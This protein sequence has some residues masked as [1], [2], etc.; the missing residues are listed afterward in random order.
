MASKPEKKAIDWQYTEGKPAEAARRK[1]AESTEGNNLA[2]GRRVGFSNEPRYNL[3]AS[4]R[5][6]FELTDGKLA[7]RKDD[8]IWFNRDAVGWTNAD[9]G[10]T[11]L[12]DLGEKRRVGKVAIRLL[13]GREQGSL[14]F[15]NEIEVIGSADGR[16]Y[17][18]L[19]K[20]S[21]VTFSEKEL[22][23]EKPESFFYLPE[24]GNAYVETFLFPIQREVRHVGL[25]IKSPTGF[26]FS[27]QL[28]VIEATPDQAMSSLTELP[29]TTITTHGL[30]IRPRQEELMITSNV[31]T[32]NWF[33]VTDLREEKRAASFYFDLPEGI[34]LKMGPAGSAV[35]R[36]SAEHPNRWVIEDLYHGKRP[37]YSNV[38]GPFYFTV[39]SGAVVAKNATATFLSDD[40]GSSHNLC[41]VPVRLVEVPKVPPLQ[42]LD[43][44]LAW[45]DE[46]EQ[47]VYPDYFRSFSHL[48]FNTVAT[49]PRNHTSS[50]GR[51]RLLKWVQTAREHHFKVLYNES[52]FHVMWRAHK[53]KDELRNRLGETVGKHACP[54]YTGPYYQEEIDRVGRIARS[55]RPDYIFFDIELWSPGAGEASRCTL[56][57]EKFRQSGGTDWAGFLIAQGTR[58]QRDLRKATKGTAPD[59]ST[60]LSGVYSMNVENSP[61]HSV[62]DVASLYPGYVDLI[63]PSLYNR[64]DVRGVER[65]IRA[66]YEFAGKR[67]LLPWLTAGT[68]GVY[69]PH[70]LEQSILEALLNGARGITYYA[71]WDFD[72]VHFYHQARALSRLAPYEELLASGAAL[73]V[74]GSEPKLMFT[75]FGTGREA[76]LLVSNDTRQALTTAVTFSG[77]KVGDIYDV[78]S[79]ETLPAGE[80]TLQALQ[81]PQDAQRLFHVTFKQPL[82]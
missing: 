15:P 41:R 74:E 70:R 47:W 40:P 51:E 56:C 5:D 24:E 19:A 50:E 67:V 10:V 21:K 16:T 38:F 4:D 6:A 80:E 66:N 59:G 3:T 17:H 79:R 8:R 42:K 1:W 46:R 45:M 52:P 2:L 30:A 78:I 34:S 76:L 62:H 20:R 29:V 26:L 32:P 28:A 81:I 57:Q 22:A 64:G 54:T 36:A 75:G 37:A 11:M 69:P 53:E 27:D 71:F 77:K 44:S 61:Y 55:I 68:Y 43:V 63:Q 73:K 35:R 65:R 18:S 39:D 14:V 7:K 23:E 9:S 72:A 48:G 60:P 58:M 13:G 49:F 33:Y 12:I 82:P 25:V 31:V